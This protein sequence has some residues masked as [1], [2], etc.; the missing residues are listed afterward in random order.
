MLSCSST[1][2]SIC[3]LALSWKY[4]P[5]ALGASHTIP[6]PVSH[7]IAVTAAPPAAAV[8]HAATATTQ[9]DIFDC[10]GKLVNA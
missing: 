7:T 3:G 6:P 10:K 2:A 9:S 4:N 5:Q 1:S 8:N